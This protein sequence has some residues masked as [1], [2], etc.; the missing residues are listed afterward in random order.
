MTCDA[1][2]KTTTDTNDSLEVHAV[3]LWPRLALLSVVVLA[4][5]GGYCLMQDRSLLE[6]VLAGETA[7]QAWRNRFPLGVFVAAIGLYVAV[8]GFS[9]PVA[10]MLSLLLGKYL[11]F[12][13]AIVV[14]SFGST[15]G[16]TLAMLV[17]RYLFRDLV[18][19]KL[20]RRWEP[21]R[22]ALERDGPFYLFTLRTMPQVPFVVVNLVM[23]V[24]SIRWQTFWWVS[25]L[26]MLPATCLFVF[27]GSQ[28]PDL[29]DLADQ[30]VSSVL[31]WPLMVGLALLGC[32]PLLTR[33]ILR[34]RTEAT[35]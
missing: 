25:Q 29:G 17:S 22:Q 21:V 24:S 1:G 13:Q 19:R 20:A 23:G 18:E 15:G 28:L 5:V 33:L 32:F 26:G 8:T 27:T 10:T 14:V 3:R 7:L 4:F 31:T 30:G 12:W 2:G 34:Q 35:R 16:A 9:I 6:R 11:G